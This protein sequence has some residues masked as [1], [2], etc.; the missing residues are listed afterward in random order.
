M[1]LSKKLILLLFSC[2]MLTAC[3]TVE[4][5]YIRNF[6]NEPAIVYIRGDISQE[7]LGRIRLHREN[8]LHVLQLPETDYKEVPQI[9][10]SAGIRYFQIPPLAVAFVGERSKTERSFQRAKF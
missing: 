6:T 1:K 3:S 10:D 5:Y 7:A 9:R 4:F 8:V 2:C